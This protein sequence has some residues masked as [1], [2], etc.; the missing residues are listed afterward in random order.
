MHEPT[1]IHPR[2]DARG[3]QLDLPDVQ[4]LAQRAAVA[5]RYRNA[6]RVP[7]GALLVDRRHPFGLVAQELRPPRDRR[8]VVLFGD[9]REAAQVALD[10]LLAL[11]LDADVHHGGRETE[12]RRCG[13]PPK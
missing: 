13:R 5:W 9:L 12:A 7:A 10:L 1:I 3:Q 8:R 11:D 2:I 6:W 4:A